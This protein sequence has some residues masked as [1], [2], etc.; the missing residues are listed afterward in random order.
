MKVNLVVTAAGTNKGKA[1]PIVGAKFLIGR[2]PNCNLRPAS[3]SVSKQHCAILIRDGEVYVQD[4]SSTNGTIVNDIPVQ[5]EQL[6]KDG[7]QLKIGPLNF[8]VEILPSPTPA[9]GTPLPNKLRSL[10]SKEGEKI[11]AA[12][13]QSATPTTELPPSRE[14]IPSSNEGDDAAAMLLG[15]DDDSPSGEQPS[16]PGGSTVMEAPAV[17]AAG[18]LIPPKKKET[19][20]AESSTAASD[21][22]KKYFR[23]TGS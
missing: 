17:D 11:R 21:L 2:D 19:D 23:R 22:L 6:L 1:I 14:K 16:I 9:D 20:Q 7:D 8:L 10:D 3:Q 12:T 15:M 4:L 18:R 13:G 5:E